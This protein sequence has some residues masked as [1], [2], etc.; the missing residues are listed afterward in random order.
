LAQDQ[1]ERMLR[2]PNAGFALRRLRADP[3]R[4]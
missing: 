3:Q 1:I 4:G 2:W